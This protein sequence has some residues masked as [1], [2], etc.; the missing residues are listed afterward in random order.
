MSG[1]TAGTARVARVEFR[2]LGDVEVHAAGQ[3]VG[4]G[5]ARQRSVLAVLLLDLGRVVS[6][7]Q[8]IDRVWGE[9]PPGSVRNVL[10]GYVAKLKA[11]IAQAGDPE[12][13]LARRPGGYLLDADPERVDL[14][15]FRRLA[16]EAAAAGDDRQAAALL[17]DALGL[18]H[19][20]ALAGLDSPWLNG[21]RETLDRQR[22]AAVLD[23]SDIALRQGQH[24]ALISELAGE[25]VAYPADERLI[26]QLMVALYQSGRQA[27]A[28]QLFEQTRRRLAGELGAD[29][30]PELRALHQR[31]LRGDPSLAA[32]GPAGHGAAPPGRTGEP[33][34]RAGEAPRELPADTTTFTGRA[35][36]L[37]ELDQLLPD[38]GA[39][40]GDPAQADAGGTAVISA[41][42]G[43]A[44]VGKTALAVHWA[45]RVAEYFPDGQLY[46]NLRGYDPDR[47][48]PAADA[49]A[50]FLRTLGVAGQDIPPE[51]DERAARYRSLLAGRRV[52]VLA[53]NAAEVAQVR[54]LL[55]GSPGCVMVVT[56]R[57][58]LAGLVARD[59]A[60]RLD[61]DL[62]PHEDAAGL[63]RA[64]IGVRAEAE[65]GAVA[66]LAGL[67]ARLPLA[68][69][70]AAELAVARPDAGARGPGRRAGRP[71][72]A[73]GPAGRRRG[74][75]H[76]GTGG[77]L[78]VLPA[79]GPYRRPRVPAAWPA[80]RP[81]LRTVRR[82]RRA[83]RPHP[84]PGKPAAR[85]AGPGAPDP[86]HRPGPVPHA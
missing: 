21:M 44:G 15:R 61:L 79:P 31:M 64:L 76:R 55:P 5:H 26:G 29:P 54:P 68:L 71:A 33:S 72:V 2:V 12:V 45:H 78:L 62:L 65:P 14:Y 39:G 7:E 35:T 67:C 20:P 42:S 19:G 66:A 11:A 18:W 24:A 51:Q 22:I 43:T 82:R 13:V 41:V 23:V 81:R 34:G 4:A 59:G 52:L 80:P 49:L 27:E 50:G 25:A 60:R 16:A 56:S 37:I 77:V 73:A 10:Y 48:V 58:S 8:L 84:R 53:D 83:H 70:V 1:E 74:S 86:A 6:A 17:R 28:L 36:E 32:P 3:R 38:P 63:L 69:R 47:P 46:V 57:D 75:A 85:P 40:A 9:N 30:G